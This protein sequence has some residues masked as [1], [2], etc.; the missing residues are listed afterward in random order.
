MKAGDRHGAAT[1]GAQTG[2]TGTYSGEV[3]GTDF[4]ATGLTGATGASRYVGATSNGPPLTGTFIVGDYV[5]DRSGGI[6]VCITAG[7]PG[8]WSLGGGGSPPMVSGR[9]YRLPNCSVQTSATLG[10]GTLR[11]IPKFIPHPLTLTRLG[12]EVTITGDV[13]SKLRLGIYA[14]DGTFR[15][16]ALVLDAGTINGDSATVQEITIS[17]AL[18]RGWYWF[19]G[20]VQ[21]VTVTQP[22]VRATNTLYEPIPVDYNTVAPT[23]GAANAGAFQS[24]VTGALPNPFVYGGSPGAAPAIFGKVA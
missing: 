14:D 9:Y 19:G 6:Y 3:T 18:S 13:G 5:I 24:G 8:T 12:A 22:T 7:T 2:T 10:V 23:A 16:G 11:L 20:A 21:V 15:P 4:K 1:G 17:Q